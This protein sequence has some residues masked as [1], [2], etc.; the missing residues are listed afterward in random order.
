MEF[1]RFEKEFK[2]KV[3]DEI[4]LIPE[5]V[6]RFLIQTPFTFDDGD[7]LKIVLKKEEKDEWQLSDEGHTFMHLSYEDID[8]DTKTRRQIIE[9][10]IAIYNMENRDGELVHTINDVRYGDALYSFIQGV[11]HISDIAYLKRERVKSAFREEFHSFVSTQVPEEKIRFDYHDPIHDQTVL[12]P[13]DC[14][15]E[16]MPRPLFLFAILND[17]RCRDATIAILK[18]EKFGVNFSAAAIFENQEEI[19]RKVLAR[20]SDVCEKQF[21][22]LQSARDRFERYLSNQLI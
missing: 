11:L 13:V 1:E 3:C 19:N 9:K 15:I 4:H 21:S 22:S 2:E 18:F 7:H 8:L 6:D 12:Y 5:G 17:D 14:M 10:S 16:V 20:F